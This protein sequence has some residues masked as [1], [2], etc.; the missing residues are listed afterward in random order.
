MASYRARVINGR[1]Q[2]DEPTDLPEGE[3]VE[4]FTDELGDD[5]DHLDEEERER[6]HAA[7]DESIEDARA[8]RV[9][10][11]EEVVRGLRR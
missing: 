6:L 7:L 9:R 4:L 10:P 11:L 2:L 1:L 8:G 3:V 5:V